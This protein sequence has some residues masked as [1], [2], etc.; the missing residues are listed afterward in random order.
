MASSMGKR[1]FSLLLSFE[2]VFIFSY[3]SFPVYLFW[4]FLAFKLVY[5]CSSNFVGSACEVDRLESL[6]VVYLVLLNLVVYC[7]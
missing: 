3:L 5:S 1:F 2:F 7:V 4:E 6:L